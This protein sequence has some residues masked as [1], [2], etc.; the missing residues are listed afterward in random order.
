MSSVRSY[1][2]SMAGW[3]RRNPYFVL[4]M[5]RE[6]SAPLFYLYALWLL[7]GIV[8]LAR[9]RSAYAAWWALATHPLA[10]LL[11]LVLLAFAVYHTWTWFSVL[12]KTAPDIDVAPKVLTAA[13]IAATALLCA[14]L[15]AFTWRAT[16]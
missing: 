10:I 13:G 5:I 7:A 14:A 15:F 16:R 2:R 4:Y 3:W 6:A 9:G 1:T 11:N 12:P 8:A